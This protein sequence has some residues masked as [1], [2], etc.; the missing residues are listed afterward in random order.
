MWILSHST[1]FSTRQDKP[2]VFALGLSTSWSGK[3]TSCLSLCDSRWWADRGDK[4]GR[5]TVWTELWTQSERP[6]VHTDRWHWH[7]VAV[8]FGLVSR[9]ALNTRLDAAP[10]DYRIWGFVVK[11]SS[12]LCNLSKF[13]TTFLG[14]LL[15]R[16]ISNLSTQTLLSLHKTV[17]LTSLL[18]ISDIL[19]HSFLLSCVNFA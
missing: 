1:F 17:P 6:A 11:L 4:E 3:T 15:L 19:T 2:N 9:P 12:A 14:Q 7:G 18:S 16:K 5:V 10:M 8:C 13:A